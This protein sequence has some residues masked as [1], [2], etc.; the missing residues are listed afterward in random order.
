MI[1][2]SMKYITKKVNLGPLEIFKGKLAFNLIKRSHEHELSYYV[3]NTC[4]ST[5][6]KTA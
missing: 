2:I 5:T 1:S 4:K 6:I 3:Q